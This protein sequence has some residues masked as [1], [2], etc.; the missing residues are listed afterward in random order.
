MDVGVGVRVAEPGVGVLSL[1]CGPAERGGEQ[2]P[3]PLREP[4][5]TTD[6]ERGVE[7]AI[8]AEEGPEQPIPHRDHRPIVGVA[9]GVDLRVVPAMQIRGGEDVV[10]RAAVHRD[11]GVL[12]LTV[13][14]PGGR[15]GHVLGGGEAHR[16]EGEPLEHAL[17]RLL[18][19]VEARRVEDV[20]ALGAVVDRVELPGRAP[21]V[22]QPVEAVV[23]QVRGQQ[24]GGQATRDAELPH[25][26]RPMRGGRPAR[27]APD[28]VGQRRA[29][30][31]TG[32]RR[33]R[34]GEEER[35]VGPGFADA[36][37]PVGVEGTPP[38][39]QQEQPVPTHDGGQQRRPGRR[40]A[41]TE[42]PLEPVR[43]KGQRTPQR[44]QPDRALSGREFAHRPRG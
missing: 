26:R 2:A 44:V 39:E 15:V 24:A 42:P 28:P 11:V 8:G 22:A 3:Q 32:Q 38:L 10:Q 21:L 23:D 27:T 35:T 1:D 43:A 9:L 36:W 16:T 5:H 25:D 30:G 37:V 4:G 12:E 31:L 13:G 6:P 17:N 14:G 19:R 34:A 20:E 7:G 29:Q 41:G 18:H 33:D 40:T